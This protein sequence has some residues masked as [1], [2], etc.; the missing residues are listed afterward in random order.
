MAMISAFDALNSIERAG[1]GL[2]E[3]EDR[4][5]RVMEAAGAEIARLRAE[6]AGLF[7]SL[8]R[9]RLDALQQDRVVGKL[10]AAERRALAAVTAQK[11]QLDALAQQ[12]DALRGKFA[13]A[14]KDRD[15]RAKAV[16]AAVEALAALEDA[17]RKRLA[18]DVA[19]QAQSARLSGAQA[20]AGA[21]D[22]KA[23]Q[24]E[25]DRD[26]KSKPYL[27]DRLFAYLWQRGYGTPAYR[28]GIIARM[29]DGYV[30]RVVNYEAARRNYF[31][32]I[33]IPKRLRAH[34]DR[35]KAEVEDEGKA[36]AAI[37][38]AALEAAGIG[39]K[40]AAHAAAARALDEADGWIAALEKE[41]ATLEQQRADLLGAGGQQSLSG[42]LDELADSL[43]R[44]D[45]RVLLRDALQTPAPDDERI[46]QR[47]QQ[48][49]AELPHRE[50]EAADA[51]RA[52]VELAR[53]RTELDRSR[54]EFRRSGYERQG[55]G[56][57]NGQLIGEVIGS[58]VGGVLSSRELG[59]ALRS[60]YRPG[61]SRPSPSSSPPWSG[62]GG[63]GSGGGSGDGF[64]TGGGF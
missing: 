37:E 15:E 32:L 31:T 64:R 44:E 57:S 3:D 45:L 51:R 46:V 17:T 55:G 10:D 39:P 53:K 54:E 34:A 4:L 8:A 43:Q 49:E 61:R 16:S 62:G 9:L 40:E 18:D 2:R 25:T 38:R 28:G 58:I 29:G 1:R 24:S 13:T 22:D 30:A 33:E 48:I 23:R 19:W 56:F 63:S 20:R 59:D 36:L 42:V 11:Q 41:D 47:L 6:Q 60:G 5:G 27:A 35:L 7:K 14:R 52:A 21:A 12:R 50:Q 26:E